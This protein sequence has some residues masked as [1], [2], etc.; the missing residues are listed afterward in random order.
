MRVHGSYKNDWSAVLSA[1]NIHF[2]SQKTAHYA[3]LETQ[4]L[5]KKKKRNRKRTSSCFQ[6]QHLVEKGWYLE[7]AAT[8]RLE[9]NED[10]TL[11]Q[12]K[13]NW[14]A[15][16]IDASQTYIECYGTIDSISHTC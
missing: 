8:I 13:K 4:A 1:F 3:Q 10:F 16:L 14:K 6:F 5:T 15:L 7:S 9:D 2:F 12:P 11:G